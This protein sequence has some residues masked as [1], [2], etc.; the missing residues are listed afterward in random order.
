M[1]MYQ[2]TISERLVLRF[3]LCFCVNLTVKTSHTVFHSA[4]WVIQYGSFVSLCSGWRTGIRRFR[5][6]CYRIITVTPLAACA[7]IT[8]ACA[9]SAVLD[10]PLMKHPYP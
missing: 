1:Q 4:I 3:R 5:T 2:K 6:G 9:I 8:R 7:P 10:G